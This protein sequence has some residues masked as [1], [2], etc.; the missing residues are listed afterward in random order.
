MTVRRAIIVLL[1]L[2]IFGG[3]ALAG[4]PRPGAE[5]RKV[6]TE[7]LG[8][9]LRRLRSSGHKGFEPWNGRKQLLLDELSLRLERSTPARVMRIMGPP[10]EIA[11]P[12][13][14]TWAICESSGDH[15]RLPTGPR[16]ALLV[17]YW[18]GG[19]DFLYF[20]SDGKAIRGHAWWMAYE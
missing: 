12:G 4:P 19:H 17:Y 3:L 7:K 13:D 11:H 20:L 8:A 10:D 18:R 2:A 5:L 14:D 1:A 15:P 6:S 9:E 16:A